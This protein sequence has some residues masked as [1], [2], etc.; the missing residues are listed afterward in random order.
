MATALHSGSVSSPAARTSTYEHPA[1]QAF[2]ILYVGF[3][4][5]PII[6][7]A[8]KFFDLLTN[9]DTYLAPIVP[10]TLGI[11]AHTFMLI[12]GVVE[13]VAGLIVMVRPQIGAYIVAL[14]LL[15]IIV[16]LF[17]LSAQTGTHA[18]DIALRDFGLSIAAVALARLGAEFHSRPLGA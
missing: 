15:G 5:L 16:N 12:V 14:W 7:G 13:I 11:T 6:A 10:Q 1:Y 9:W 17:I 8:D 18:Y 3:I 4:A 2:V